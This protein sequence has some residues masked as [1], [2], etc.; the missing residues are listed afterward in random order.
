MDG[1]SMDT[2]TCQTNHLA[3]CVDSFVNLLK[4]ADVSQLWTRMRTRFT[5]A[6]HTELSRLLPWLTAGL[7]FTPLVPALYSFAHQSSLLQQV[8]LMYTGWHLMTEVHN[9]WNLWYQKAAQP[10]GV[11]DKF[12]KL[13]V[14]TF[15]VWCSSDWLLHQPIQAALFVSGLASSVCGLT[16][17]RWCTHRCSCCSL[18]NS[19]VLL[20]KSCIWVRLIENFQIIKPL[21]VEI[22]PFHA[23]LLIWSSVSLLLRNLDEWWTGPVPCGAH[24]ANALLEKTVITDA[25][26]QK[27]HTELHGSKQLYHQYG[28]SLE[29]LLS[30]FA[31]N[32]FQVKYPQYF[33]EEF[34]RTDTHLLLNNNGTHWK[35]MR[36]TRQRWKLFDDG[37]VFD[38]TAER[39]ALMVNAYAISE[40]CHV[41]SLKCG[42][43]VPLERQ[44]RYTGPSIFGKG[45]DNVTTCFASSCLILVVHCNKCRCCTRV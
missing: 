17:S 8:Y 2:E 38:L 9:A 16:Y 4:L 29:V 32:G 20:A 5:A 19:A 27:R 39:A 45:C 14:L 18:R 11:W 33:V 34:D 22:Y 13:I 12:L 15:C 41:I 40:T 10:D 37:T 31:E 25:V 6:E 44:E 1:I 42:K 3:Q 26:L 7:I 35:S 30:L 36:R 23:A 24:A 43:R 21:W 28:A